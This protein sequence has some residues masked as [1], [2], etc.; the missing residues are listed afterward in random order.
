D[1]LTRIEAAKDDDRIKGIYLD[2]STI[3]ADF[4]T[5]EEIRNAL[6]DFKS[7]KKFIISYSEY[8]SQSSYYLAS[9]ADYLYLNP[10]GYLD[11]RGLAS[12]SVFFKGTLEKLGVET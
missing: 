9:I 2:L 3:G 7:S 10:E 6:I 8:Y 11:F 4:A 1:I 5:L 12:Q